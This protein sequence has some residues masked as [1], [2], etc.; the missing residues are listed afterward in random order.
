MRGNPLPPSLRDDLGSGHSGPIKVVRVNIPNF[1]NDGKPPAAR[2]KRRFKQGG[3]FQF[4]IPEKIF[5]I[6]FLNF[7][8]C[9]SKYETNDWSV[10][11]YLMKWGRFKKKKEITPF[12]RW[13][14]YFFFLHQTIFG[15]TFEN[16]FFFLSCL[17]ERFI[18]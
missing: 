16:N 12:Q 17:A 5:L 10:L 3:I 9:L 6:L 13:I 8:V 7:S 11:F 18:L 1:F 14:M 2:T 4:W 15:Y